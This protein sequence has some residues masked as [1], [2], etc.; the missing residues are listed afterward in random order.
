M[1]FTNDSQIAVFAAYN[2]TYQY[3]NG[4]D[5][6]NGTISN[7]TQCYMLRDPY[8]PSI[9]SNGTIVNGTGCSSPINVIFTHHALL[10]RSADYVADSLTRYQR[11]HLRCDLHAL[12]S[13]LRG[14]AR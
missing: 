13:F 6:F 5:Y 12:H 11:H 1:P 8:L 14:G 7:A 2:Y 4:S 3:A 10:G 9:F